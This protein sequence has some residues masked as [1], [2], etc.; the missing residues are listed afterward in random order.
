MLDI[1]SFDNCP[2]FQLSWLCLKTCPLRTKLRGASD[3]R[4]VPPVPCLLGAVSPVSRHPRAVLEMRPLRR[5][6]PEWP[7]LPPRVLR[8]PHLRIGPEMCTHHRT[9]Q[10]TSIQCRTVPATSTHHPIIIIKH[11]RI[12]WETKATRTREDTWI[13]VIVTRY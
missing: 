12:G 3:H 4:A 1:L 6:V 9:V 5:A 8:L 10:E 2:L 11:Q 7:R 13:L